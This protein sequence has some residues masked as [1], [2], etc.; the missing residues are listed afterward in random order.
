M[1]LDEVRRI[2]GIFAIAGGFLIA[3]VQLWLQF[4]PQSF[5]AAYFHLVGLV[6]IAIGLIGLYLIQYKSIGGF[7][8]FSFVLLTVSLYLWIGY[9]W[10][11]TFVFLDLLK[12]VPD[13]TNIVL[14]SMIYGK[15]LALYSL[16]LSILIFSGISLWKGILSRWGTIFL[17]LAPFSI[18]IPYGSIAAHFMAAVSFIWSGITLCKGNIDETGIAAETEVEAENP[19]QELQK[20]KLEAN[21]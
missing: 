20:K 3:L 9:H 2:L 13:I 7:G 1:T 10:F 6:S 11:H 17:F 16:L 4:D 12:S 15:N 19:L 8:F 18:L 5:I 21:Q 14:P